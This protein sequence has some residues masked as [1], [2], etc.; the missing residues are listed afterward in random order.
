[1]RLSEEEKTLR[2]SLEFLLNLDLRLIEEK[3]KDPEN[4]EGNK[5]VDYTLPFLRNY[6]DAKG[7]GVFTGNM[8]ESYINRY[9]RKIKRAISKWSKSKT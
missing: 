6:S 1:M 2:K 5:L 9:F 7:L 4:Y 8:L 3:I